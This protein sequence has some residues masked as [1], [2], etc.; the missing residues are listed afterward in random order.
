MNLSPLWVEWLT[1]DGL[2]AVHWSTLG[3]FNA[4]DEF[5]FQYA[6]AHQYLMLTQDLDFSQILFSTAESGPSV[7]LVRIRDEFD[8]EVRRRITATLHSCAKE[9]KQ[10]ALLVIDN[11]KARLRLLPLN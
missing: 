10:V 7:V 8:R 4:T 5:I 2:N 11:K 6:R 3:A 1:Q 9:L